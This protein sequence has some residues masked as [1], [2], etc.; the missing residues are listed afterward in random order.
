[1]LSHHKF[2][3]ESESKSTKKPPKKGVN[4]DNI[5]CIVFQFVKLP[6]EWKEEAYSV[7]HRR[8]IESTCTANTLWLRNFLIF[9]SLFLLRFII[10][11]DTFYHFRSCFQFSFFKGS[12]SVQHFSIDLCISI[13]KVY[14][15]PLMRM[16]DFQRMSYFFTINL[17]CL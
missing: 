2:L 10:W 16:Q 9:P 17:Q 5:Y 3:Y 4:C 1:M 11:V 6:Q 14:K 12:F 7:G 8:R 13:L 15:L